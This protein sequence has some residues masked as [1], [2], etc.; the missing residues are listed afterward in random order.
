MLGT[1][2]LRWLVTRIKYLPPDSMVWAES[3]AA[4]PAKADN[5]VSIAEWVAANQKHK[6]EVNSG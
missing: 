6:K 3:R 1:R 2:S 4:E 5:V